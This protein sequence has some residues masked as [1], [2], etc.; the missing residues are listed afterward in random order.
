M[1]VRSRSGGPRINPVLAWVPEPSANMQATFGPG[2]FSVLPFAFAP[3]R[4][5]RVSQFAGSGSFSFC[6]S[7]HCAALRRRRR[8]RRHDKASCM[9]DR[10]SGGAEPCLE[11]CAQPGLRLAGAR[12]P[13]RNPG[14]VK[15]KSRD[16]GGEG[17]IRA[18]PGQT[19]FNGRRKRSLRVLV[20]MRFCRR[21]VSG[22][23]GP[24]P[25]WHPRKVSF[26]SSYLFV[27][28]TLYLSRVS[29]SGPPSP[30]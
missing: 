28:P 23:A 11:G 30:T 4:T 15:K 7:Y 21:G 19:V 25:R 12:A 18:D 20:Q 6:S 3:V 10:S 9:I 27:L 1:R 22:R 8:R 29:P 24:R 16:G 14:A 5:K 17:E 26:P 2:L 13:G